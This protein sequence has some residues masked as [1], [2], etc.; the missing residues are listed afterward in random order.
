MSTTLTP[1]P[2]G[3]D[4]PPPA[5]GTPARG[6]SRVIA[7]LVIAFGVLV[8]L[9]AAGSAV[10]A[11]ISAA[12][13]QTTTRST[14]VTGVSGIDVDVAAGSLRIEFAD[15]SE[16]ELEVTGTW[17]ADRW[18]LSAEGDSLVVSS[19][20]GWFS[21][22]WGFGGWPFGDNG[23][24]NAILRLPQSLEGS[25]ADLTLAAGEL[26]VADGSF[27]D[28]ELDMGAG[29]ARVEASVTDITADVSAGTAELSIRGA[30]EA[31]FTVSAGSLEAELSG[32]QPQ[33]LELE[34]S[35]G[36]LDVTVPEGEYD[37][38][39]E[40]SAG[41]FDNRIGSTPGADSTVSVQV[42]AGKATLQVGSAR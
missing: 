26:V 1:P 41:E 19:P 30:R 18:T 3:T 5:G 4:T 25:D 33:S 28:F 12:S 32:R 40:V 39:S 24:G 34:V 31:S 21:D 6:A 35:A 22:G 36:S 2:A 29:S 23:V 13:V 9:G 15:V 42:S 11:T 14:P 8:I 38:S 17:G 16:A 7:I 10:F 37:V 27:G 20:Q